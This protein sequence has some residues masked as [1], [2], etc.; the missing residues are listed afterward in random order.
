MEAVPSAEL[1]PG[2]SQSDEQE[3]GLTYEELS[4]LGRLRKIERL[5]ALSMYNRLKH[6]WP[7]S[8]TEV[9]YVP[10]IADCCQGAAFYGELCSQP[11]Q[12]DHINAF[13]PCRR[14]LT[15]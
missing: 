1:I 9:I 8:P 14:L 15:R 11:T 3:M 2:Q 13:L 12:N 4:I 10:F 6:I 7:F 5:G